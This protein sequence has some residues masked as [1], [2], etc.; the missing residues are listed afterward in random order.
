MTRRR[1]RK[2]QHLRQ[3][4]EFQ[5][6]YERRMRVSDSHLLIY[7]ALRDSPDPHAPCS[8]IGLSV[9]RKNGPAVTRNRIKRLLREAFR[10]AQHELPSGL[11][12]ILIPRAGA[13][14]QLADYR[15]SLKR[16]TRRLWKRLQQEP[17]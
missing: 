7:A 11:D 13:N 5:R 14:S 17:A 6:V 3:P 16:L 10:Q 1:F 15:D 12:L 9:S 2:E 8:R 4:L